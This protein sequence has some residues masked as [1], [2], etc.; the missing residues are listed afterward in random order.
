MNFR[1]QSLAMRSAPAVC[2]SLLTFTTLAAL[3]HQASASV[4]TNLVAAETFGDN[5][6]GDIGFTASPTLFDDGSTDFFTVLPN[7]GTRFAPIADGENFV[8][9][10]EDIDGDSPTNMGSLTSAGVDL[11]SYTNTCIEIFLAA[12]GDSLGSVGA[13]TSF[14]D[15]TEYDTS[16][17][18]PSLNDQM[19]VSFAADG[20][21]FVELVRFEPA[22]VN[23]S[24]QVISTNITAEG[25]ARNLT[26]VPDISGPSFSRVSFSPFGAPAN[27]AVR[28]S[29]QSNG[30]GEFFAVDSI[31]FLGDEIVG[32]NAPVVN[33]LQAATVG[34]EELL[35]TSYSFDV[36]YSD[37]SS[38]SAASIDVNDI[39]VTDP[40]NNN[41]IVT[42]ASIS[43]SGGG[44]LS[45]V[46][47]TVT[48]PGGDWD[49]GDNGTYTVSVNANEVGDDASPQLFAPAGEIGTFEV[50]ASNSGPNVVNVRAPNVGFGDIGGTSYSFTI[51]YFDV[52]GIDLSSIDIGDVT[53][54]REDESSLLVLSAVPLVNGQITSVTYTIEPPNGMWNISDSAEV[55]TIGINLFEVSDTLGFSLGAQPELA[56][57]SFDLN[58]LVRESFESNGVGFDS[59]VTSANDF[60]IGVNDYW[61]ATNGSDISTGSQGS[62]PYSGGDGLRYWA[63]QDLVA[64]SDTLEIGPVSITN[65]SNLNFS[66]LFAAD[67]LAGDPPT[68]R[69]DEGEGLEIAWSIDGSPFIDG[70]AF[71]A[72]GASN[73]VLLQ[74]TNLNGIG[75]GTQLTPDFATFGFSIPDEGDEITIRIT[76]ILSTSNEDVAFDNL[77]IT[78]ISPPLELGYDP[79]VSTGD[80]PNISVDLTTGFVDA[81]DAA[82]DLTYFIISNDNPNLL[83][84]VIIDGVTNMLT[85]DFRAESGGVANILIGATNSGGSTETSLLTVT[86]ENPLGNLVFLEDPNSATAS[87]STDNGAGGT[88]PVENLYDAN[89]TAEGFDSVIPVG[90]QWGGAGAGPHVVVFEYSDRIVFDGIA[91][92]QR[93]GGI[94]TADKVPSMRVWVSETDPG[95]ASLALPILSTPPAAELTD[96]IQDT[97][98][99][100]RHYPLDEVLT[101]RYVI[102]QLATGTFNP[103]G[104]E[105][106]LTLYAPIDFKIFEFQP[107]EGGSVGIF[108]S[109]VGRTYEVERSTTLDPDEWMNIG[110]LNGRDG[111]TSFF[112]PDFILSEAFYRVGEVVNP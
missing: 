59:G 8:F 72:S 97:T 29:F 39:T 110:T 12:P 33:N 11:S 63:G 43:P 76:G 81:N 103:G 109:V 75:N 35:A 53:V 7:N 31:R 42:G 105:L 96:L 5:Q 69:Y 98:L 20:V 95:P 16:V 89:P 106:A 46:T 52:G 32:N 67:G 15:N 80:G 71:K 73:S 90:G 100:L 49:F 36:L 54:R 37:D 60:Y 111:A 10:V 13:W 74:D 102:F 55:F 23:A 30:S 2:K 9:A 40:D 78:G 85:L 45:T 79:I 44:P 17:N 92:V 21:N 56:T 70:L 94:P 82:S 25:T 6:G 77:K 86:V 41:L 65:F 108:S 87:S 1:C 47:Y 101:G 48:P 112:D 61:T 34:E 38:I 51:D 64:G 104:A 58:C 50:V 24:N 19:V 3:C 27:A 99:T 57:F 88:L 66:G 18:D 107:Y 4:S 91:Y 26:V 14:N 62:F 93:L 28:I 68:P 84:A 22:N 83:N